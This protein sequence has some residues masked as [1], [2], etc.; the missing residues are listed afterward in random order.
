MDGQPTPGAVDWFNVVLY[1]NEVI[2]EN[3]QRIEALEASLAT[4]TATVLAMQP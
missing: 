3:R 4:L 2:K 1:Q